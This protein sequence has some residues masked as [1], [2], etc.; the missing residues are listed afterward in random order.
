MDKNDHQQFE[1]YGTSP[2]VEG[3]SRLFQSI[4]GGI[5]QLFLALWRGLL[6][7][8]HFLFSKWLAL[9]LSML[10]FGAASLLLNSFSD[11][12]YVNYMELK[13]RFSIESQL[14][15]DIGYLNSLIET[16]NHQKLADVLNL[17]LESAEKIESIKVETKYLET[18]KI[19]FFDSYIATLDSVTI[20]NIDF[21]ELMADESLESAYSRYRI[22]VYS[23][24]PNVFGNFEDAFLKLIYRKTAIF[25]EQKEWRDN[26]EQQKLQTTAKV[27][28]LDSLKTLVKTTMVKAADLPKGEQ[29]N[30]ML[31]G[32]LSGASNEYLSGLESIFDRAD[33]Y[34]DEIS[35]I[36]M[37][38]ASDGDILKVQTKFTP[39][40]TLASPSKTSATLMGVLFGFLVF[41]FFHI[42][43]W[44]YKKG[45]EI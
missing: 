32:G 17:D 15:N 9:G 26:L 31:N 38:L 20:N 36:N 16:G 11:D 33:K 5:A 2:L 12:H 14:I 6:F 41:S 37:K 44:L 30:I 10:V 23:K 29:S 8:I 28:E 25:K 21:T 3:V 4:G 18:E 40:G 45:A 35:T 13:P 24:D 7:S 1:E 42:V 22:E 39:L 34:S 19:K 27:Q 43:K